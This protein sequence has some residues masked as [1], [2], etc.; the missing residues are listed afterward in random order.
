[1]V[2]R[3]VSEGLD[4]DRLGSAPGLALR[5]EAFQM[6]QWAQ[7]SVAAQSL[8]QMAARGAKGDPAL[9]RLIRE[10]QD[11]V[12]EWLDRDRAR[13]TAVALAPD[14][15]DRRAEADNVARLAA[16]DT[17]IGEIDSRL[18]VQFPEYAALANP[19]PLTVEQVRAELRD[20]EALVFFLDTADPEETFVWVITKTAGRWIRSQLGTPSLRREVAALRCGLDATS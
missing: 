18:A 11:L 2:Y 9:G 17:R 5:R 14:K 4:A 7:A 3:L 1:M 20:D 6:A 13:T 10:R 19:A 8:A 15:R 12:A 16:I